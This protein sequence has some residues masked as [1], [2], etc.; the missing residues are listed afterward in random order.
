MFDGFRVNP[1]DYKHR[2][3]QLITLISADVKSTKD[4]MNMFQ[5]LVSEVEEIKPL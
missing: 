3:E 1:Q 5:E 4:G 2:I